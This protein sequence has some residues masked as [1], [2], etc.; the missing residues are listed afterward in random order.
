MSNLL[1]SPQS[2]SPVTSDYDRLVASLQNLDPGEG[3]RLLKQFMQVY[4]SF[5]QGHNDLGVLYLQ[6]GNPTLALAHHEKA[7]RLQPDNSTFRKNLADFYAVELGWLDDAVD[8]YLDI[9]KRNPRDTEALIA[10]GRLGC[11]MEGSVALEQPSVRPAI[12]A[13]VVP[14]PAAVA[15]HVESQPACVASQSWQPPVQAA[16]PAPR[17]SFDELYRE[18]AE[19][20]GEGHFGEAR[21]VLEE[22]L[23]RQP[24]NAVLYNDLGVVCYNL[25]DVPAARANYEKATALN[26]GNA[27]FARNLADLYF[28]ELGRGDDAIR[29]YLDLHRK[30]PRDVEV[31]INLGHICAAVDRPAEAASFYRRALEIEPW[32]GDARQALAAAVE[33]PIQQPAPSPRRTAE[34]IHAEA[35]G[36]SAANRL[37]EAHALL[38]E[39]VHQY[40]DHA[41]GQNDLGVLRYQLGDVRGA[42]Q[43]YEQA[44]KAQPCNSTFRKNLAD[45][46]FVELGRADDAIR[47]YLEMFAEQPRD[48]GILLSLG[49]ICVA[50]GRP[51]EAKSFFRRALEIEPWNAEAR[52]ALLGAK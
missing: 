16:A 51:E 42:A 27:V 32:S 37:H 3:I 31:L 1:A 11:A 40:P 34:D 5:A 20:A 8:I 30:N 47:I 23:G 33:Q 18:A 15:V 2:S 43:A 7:N 38:E 41:V 46:Y 14:Q 6:A 19:L 4:P 9:L 50:V 29:I 21:G 35:L 39:L 22:L 36:Y 24:G 45:L 48:V 49:Q 26:P 17:K 25:G 10:L 13:A 28:A 44:V 12:E 52:E